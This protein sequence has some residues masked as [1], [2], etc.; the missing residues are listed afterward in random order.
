MQFS[1]TFEQFWCY[2]IPLLGAYIADTYLGRYRTIMWSVGI[3]IV[4]HI[5]LTASGAPGLLA[6]RSHALACFIIGLIIMGLGTGTSSLS[7]LSNNK[8]TRNRWLQAQH[9]ALGR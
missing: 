8:L 9:L 1:N 4:G 6:E 7:K 2:V 3:A 5:I